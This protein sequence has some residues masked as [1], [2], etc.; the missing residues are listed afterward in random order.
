[1]AQSVTTTNSSF[2]DMLNQYLTYD[3]LKTEAKKRSWLWDKAQH[4][5]GWKG[6][7]LIVPF[8]SAAASSISFGSLTADTD[9]SQAINVRGSISTYKEVWGTLTFNQKDLVQH[10]GKVSEKSFLKLLP[11]QIEGFMN[12]FTEKMS[13]QI[14]SGSVQATLTADGTS[15]GDI[16]VDR[17]ERF[18]I[19]EK[20]TLDDDNSAAADYYIRE[21]NL[22]TGVISLSASAH[23]YATNAAGATANVS[24]YTVAQ[25]AKLYMVGALTDSANPFTS[26][27]AALLPSGTGIGSSSLYGVTKTSSPYTQAIAVD[28]ASVNASNILAKIFD[29]FTQ[30]RKVGKGMPN[31]VVMSWKN[32]G[33]CMKL[34][35]LAKGGY[36]QVDSD[37]AE[38]YGW[39]SITVQGVS[40]S[41]EL[42]GIPEMDDDVIF[43]LDMGAFKFVSNGGIRKHKTPDGLE[44]YTKRATT[45][46]SYFVDLF[47]FGDLVV[48]AP[49]NCGVL[50]SIP[51]YTLVP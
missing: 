9:V 49:R 30:I 39:T 6:G 4:D 12:L 50:H 40:G 21:I 19:G 25:N 22:N 23:N 45:G 41:V 14:L 13:Q 1:M 38:I 3:L 34:I 8:E 29:A 32:L 7:A 36:K 44:F 20:V 24:A 28:G 33:S 16:T 17:P 15:G 31:K 48:H 46:Y 37:K 35:E 2:N 47:L 27:K 43:F 5:E 11:G 42:I 18:H 10:D 51:N 26:L